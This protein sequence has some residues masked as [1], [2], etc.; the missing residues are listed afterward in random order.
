MPSPGPATQGTRAATGTKG[1]PLARARPPRRRPSSA[2][3]TCR[4]PCAWAAA[5]AA[6]AASLV[7]V[8][9]AHRLRPPPP[10]SLSLSPPPALMRDPRFVLRSPRPGKGEQR[11]QEAPRPSPAAAPLLSVRAGGHRARLRGSERPPRGPPVGLG[12]AEGSAAA[13]GFS[14]RRQKRS[15]SRRGGG[16]RAPEPAEGYAEAGCASERRALCRCSREGESGSMVSCSHPEPS[17]TILEKT[18][19]SR[20]R[21]KP[22]GLAGRAEYPGRQR[23]P[24][25]PARA[26]GLDAGARGGPRARAGGRRALLRPKSSAPPPSCLPSSQRKGGWEREVACWLLLAAPLGSVAI[27]APRRG[28][29]PLLSPYGL[30]PDRK[31][32]V[33][34]GHP[35]EPSGVLASSLG[36]LTR[37]RA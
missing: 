16:W 18:R 34:L 19:I 28:A 3:L 6:A 21:R 24:P 26:P 32:A 25:G 4:R 23:A 10:R 1:A 35:L 9:L 30:F 33:H 13:R 29:V 11:P 37:E 7:V 2:S 8:A 15:P 12:G 14:A 5:P 17:A 22:G 27:F 36:Y 20:P 31:Q